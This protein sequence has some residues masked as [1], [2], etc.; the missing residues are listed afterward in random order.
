MPPCHLKKKAATG[1]SLPFVSI[2]TPTF[3]RRPFWEHTLQMF[4]NQ[5]YPKELMEWIIVDDC[6]GDK[7]KDI[8]EKS[9]IS[10]IKYYELPE[11][12]HLGAKRNL[13]HQY[14]S[15][16]S[17]IIIY[18]DDDDYYPPERVSHAVEQLL[19]HPDVL[20]AGSSEIH[21]V[22][23]GLPNHPPVAIY[24]AGPYGPNHATAGTFAFRKKLLLQ[25]RYNDNAAL[26]EEKEF[27]NDYTVPFVQLDPLKTI[28]VFSH[29]HNTFDKRKM[30]DNIHPSYFKQC[31]RTVTDFI[32]KPSES[33]IKK[34]F[35]EEIDAKLA[36]YLPGRPENKPDVQIQMKVIEAER[37]EMVRNMAAQQQVPQIIMQKEGCEPQVLSLE[38]CASL[39]Q[40]QSKLI[41]ELVRR[42]KT[43][44]ER[45]AQLESE[46]GQN[47]STYSSLPYLST[48][49][50]PS[51]PS[52]PMIDAHAPLISRPPPLSQ[53]SISPGLVIN[54]NIQ[55]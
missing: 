11:K 38:Q 7:I 28:L 35:L 5:T 41:D 45:I 1:S 32:R 47:T 18:M 52:P 44:N 48:F 25:H 8:I 51:S 14:C 13:M 36:K 31:T 34:F 37:A 16:D 20:A 42:I 55:I 23:K 24:Q 17:E 49:P 12:M 4:R 27:L 9:G 30:L 10:Q 29:D 3:G 40:N 53:L 26:A 39:L 46:S 6:P 43:A 2:C 21:I 50:L 33:H 15:P 54:Q 19:A 22:Y